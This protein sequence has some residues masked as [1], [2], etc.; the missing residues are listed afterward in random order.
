[1]DATGPTRAMRL[2]LTADNA[3]WPWLVVAIGAVIMY[4]PSFAGITTVSPFS[5]VM[6]VSP[7]VR[8]NVP[9]MHVSAWKTP[10]VA[11]CS[12]SSRNVWRM[13]SK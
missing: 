9:S 7:C 12:V 8:V 11:S 4:A 6:V 2:N 1:M 13:V 10:S 5:S 3:W